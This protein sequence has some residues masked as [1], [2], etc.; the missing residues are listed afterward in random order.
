MPSRNSVYA[1]S[2]GLLLTLLLSIASGSYTLWS[3][4]HQNSWDAISNCLN[5]GADAITSSICKNGINVYKGLTIA[6]YIIIWL[7]MIY[8][9]VIVDN[10]VEQ[11]DEEMSLQETRQMINAISQPRVTVAP[12]AVPAYASF[13]P[14][15]APQGTGY[16]FSHQNQS[17]GVRGNNSMAALLVLTFIWAAIHALN[18]LLKPSSSHTLLPSTAFTRYSQRNAWSE[19]TT[20]VVLKG[21]HLR[22]STTYWNLSHDLL[23]TSLKNGRIAGLNRVVKRLYDLGTVMGLIGMLAALGFLLTTGGVSAVSL[24]NKLWGSTAHTPSTP[25]EVVGA[26]SKRSVDAAPGGPEAHTSSSFIK[27]IIPGVTVPLSHLPVILAAVFLAQIVH[28]LGHAIAAAIEALPI[29]SAGASFTLVV[30]S[31]FVTFSNAALDS[32][33]PRARARVVAAGPFHNIILWCLLALIGYTRLGDIFWFVGYRDISAHGKVVVD[34]DAVSSHSEPLSA[35]TERSWQQSPLYGYLP[36]G[37]VITALDDTLLGS[38]NASYDGSKT[39]GFS[40]FVSL[41]SSTTKGCLDPLPILGHVTA[42]KRC[43]TDIQCS[44]TSQCIKPAATEHLLRLTVHRPSGEGGPEV[45]LWSGPAEEIWEEVS[46]PHTG[47][48]FWE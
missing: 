28:E 24:A 5:G 20:T 4:F 31:A 47:M 16:A 45:I 3:L 41:D 26:L 7:L 13:P 9:Y 34:V 40:C 38:Q 2:M 10:Y 35:Q 27:P 30:P 44:E 23:S 29:L 18:Y 17:Y 12:V 21:L 39:P 48:V 36:L 11:L 19:S 37:S 46:L 14:S 15:Q 32:L 33:T 22:I 43:T 25:S 1:Y 6:L 8:A 42:A